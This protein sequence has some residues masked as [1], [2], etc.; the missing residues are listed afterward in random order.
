MSPVYYAASTKTNKQNQKFWAGEMSQP[1]QCQHKDLEWIA[2]VY[3]KSPVWQ[4]ADLLELGTQAEDPWDL[5]DRS[6]AEPTGLRIQ[7]ETS[8][9]LQKRGW[10]RQHTHACLPLAMWTHKCEL[11]QIS[12]TYRHVKC[13]IRV[14]RVRAFPPL[15][16]SLPWF[17]S[18]EM[19]IGLARGTWGM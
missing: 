9:H 3:S 4:T 11:K 12:P 17:Y 7:S 8:S 5:L 19:L 18:A 13:L 6:L 16:P 2:N 14:W 10:G 1:V 15:R